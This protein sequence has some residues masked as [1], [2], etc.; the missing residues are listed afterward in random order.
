METLYSLSPGFSF[1]DRGGLVDPAFEAGLL[2][3]SSGQMLL[4]NAE[5]AALLI[6]FREP[7]SVADAAQAFTHKLT[8]SPSDIQAV[9]QAFVDTFFQQGILITGK[10][11]QQKLAYPFPTLQPGTAVKNYLVLKELSATPPVGIYLVKSL[12]G[13]RYVLKKLF[14]HPKASP[15]AVRAQK[16]EFAH[17]FHVLHHLEGCPAVGQLVEFD[18]DE[19]IG[20]VDYF[21]GVSLRKFI[22]SNHKELSTADRISLFHQLL[23][24]MDGLHSRGVLHGDIHYSN[25]LVNKKKQVRLIDFDLAYFWRDRTKKN[26]RHGGITDFTPPERITDDVFHKSAGP[27]DFRAEVYQIGIIG[28]FIVE[29][30]LPFGGHTWREK[31]ATIRQASLTWDVFV[32][33]VIRDLIETALQKDPAQ[34]FASATAMKAV[35]I[36]TVFSARAVATVPVTMPVAGFLVE[37]F[38][39]NR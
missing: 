36:E 16:K 26:L 9:I 15:G 12:T 4:L 21:A 6:L 38:G 24:C 35:G 2:N 17:E 20:V 5:I 23:N 39:L 29:G 22:T 19:N 14:I 11:L 34:R 25:V 31:V 8:A 10:Q 13:K 37:P 27:P 1:I 30:R 7:A 3:K 18:A 32:P 28:Y 33:V